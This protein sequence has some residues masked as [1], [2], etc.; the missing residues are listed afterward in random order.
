LIE[1]IK[2]IHVITVLISI[3]GFILRGIWM[4]KDSPLLKRRWVKITPHINDAVLLV[5]GITLAI[6]IQQYPFV[7]G[8]LTAK[9]IALLI[10]IGLGFKTFRFG[11]SKQQRIT[12]WMLAIFVFIYMVTVAINKQTLPFL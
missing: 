5:S 12:T 3:S 4:I 1:T 2:H 7:H 11:K 6:M 9:I 8:W 10:Y